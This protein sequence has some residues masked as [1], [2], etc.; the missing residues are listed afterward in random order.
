MSTFTDL[1]EKEG[2]SIS[3][4]DLDRIQQR[5][6]RNVASMNVK[7]CNSSAGIRTIV[8]KKGDNESFGF[9]YQ[10]FMFRRI[11]QAFSERVF[12][13]TSVHPKGL[14]AANGLKYGDIILSVNGLSAAK[15]SENAVC[16][17]LNNSCTLRLVVSTDK[18][19]RRAILATKKRELEA[20]LSDK[21]QQLKSLTDREESLQAMYNKLRR[22][23][24]P[25]SY[26][27]NLNEAERKAES[28]YNSRSPSPDEVYWF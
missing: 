9:T 10:M 26:A 20:K 18:H 2:K 16:Q 5:F 28:E 14:A 21:L 27:D 25:T 3:R 22:L 6:G 24:S 1:C 15:Y 8:L 4:S 11:K 23:S 17:V 19:L 13:V 7:Q 12:Y